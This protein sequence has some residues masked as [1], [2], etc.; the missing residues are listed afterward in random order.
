[1]HFSPVFSVLSTLLAICATAS[2]SPAAHDL[3]RRQFVPID[4]IA[5]PSAG[6]AISS[7]S[8]FSFEYNVV[9]FCQTGYSPLGIYLVAGPEPPTGSSLNATGGFPVG[10]YVEFLGS[11]L[12]ANFGT[13]L[14]LFV[15]RKSGLKVLKGLPTM[16]PGPPP[17]TLT[18]PA[19]DP[20]LDG[21]T[22]YLA[23]VQTELTCPVSRF[24]VQH[25]SIC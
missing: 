18:I 13:S 4:G 3:G 19:L 2:A 25:Y 22:V 7:G 1:M 11:Y 5:Q 14:L 24:E 9:N 8:P 17:S 10:S 6:T 16:A 20:S 23:I 12:V 21:T 15:G